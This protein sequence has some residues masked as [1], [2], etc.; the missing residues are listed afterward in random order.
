M[1]LKLRKFLSFPILLFKKWKIKKERKQR[2]KIT[3]DVEKVVEI[4]EPTV[5]HIEKLSENIE[6]EISLTHLENQIEA[7]S[8]VKNE[9]TKKE[10]NK[11]NNQLDQLLMRANARLR[12]LKGLTFEELDLERLIIEQRQLLSKQQN[13]ATRKESIDFSKIRSCESML[14]GIDLNKLDLYPEK[15]TPPIPK[16]V[17]KELSD[18]L[19]E[20]LIDKSF[21]VEGFVNEVEEQVTLDHE[22]SETETLIDRNETEKIIEYLKANGANYFYHVTNKENRLSIDQAGLY[23]WTFLEKNKIIYLNELTKGDSQKLD[24][25]K[26]KQNYV[27]LSFCRASPM[28]YKYKHLQTNIIYLIDINVL[29]TCDYEFSNMNATDRNVKFGNTLRFLKDYI[30]LKL[31][32]SRYDWNWVEIDRKNYQAEIL[33]KDHIPPEYIKNTIR[34]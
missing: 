29:R 21:E 9:L 30:K 3:E 20:L 5:E 16:Y 22:V 13:P 28:F 8:K 15:A 23:S 10:R 7:I 6:N 32:Q 17:E 31:T 1:W 12:K 27:R 14:N 11:Y 34:F 33:I 2:E 19:A 24:R 4:N 26:N 18:I 25:S